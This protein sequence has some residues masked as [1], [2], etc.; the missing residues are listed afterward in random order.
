[1]NKLVFI[2]V[3]PTERLREL[4][5]SV[6]SCFNQLQKYLTRRRLFWLKWSVHDLVLVISPPSLVKVAS[7]TRPCLK[8]GGITLNGGEGGVDCYI[9]HLRVTSGDLK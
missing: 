6:V 8:L 2:A 4:C 3:P 7:N 5:R 9:F 1:M